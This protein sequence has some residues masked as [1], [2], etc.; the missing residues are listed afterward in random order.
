[1][2]NI[3]LSV[4]ITFSI[5]GNVENSGYYL[6]ADS[7]YTTKFGNYLVL[8]NIYYD[9]GT[10]KTNDDVV[11]CRTAYLLTTTKKIKKQLKKLSGIKVKKLPA[12][13]HTQ[14]N[15]VQT[16]T[17]TMLNNERFMDVFYGIKMFTF[18]SI[19]PVEGICNP[20]NCIC[21]TKCAVGKKRIPIK[22]LKPGKYR[23]VAVSS[24]RK[25]F[26]TFMFTKTK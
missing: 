25:E 18:A 20:D 10:K 24:Q 16:T 14:Y 8:A 4:L 2:L 26:A 1:M 22:K 19:S 3:L 6:K 12:L 9:N 21:I 17:Y 23:F 13:S 7:I 5:N 15:L 11:F